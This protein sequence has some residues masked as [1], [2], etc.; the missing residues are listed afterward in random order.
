MTDD[1]FQA[2]I[3][4]MRRMLLWMS[5]LASA[6]ILFAGFVNLYF[7]PDPWA[8]APFASTYIIGAGLPWV[9]WWFLRQAM[10][11]DGY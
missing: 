6:F 8:L 10:K 7:A 4:R 5:P 2:E 3:H 11:R 9:G 1:D